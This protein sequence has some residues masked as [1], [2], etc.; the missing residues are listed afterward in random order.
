MDPCWHDGERVERAS[1]EDGGDG[2]EE[3]EVAD[4]PVGVVEHGTLGMIRVWPHCGHGKL[5]LCKVFY[6]PL[7]SDEKTCVKKCTTKVVH[8]DT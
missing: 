2:E 6:C 4:A 5:K 1:E 8:K 3:G 7:K